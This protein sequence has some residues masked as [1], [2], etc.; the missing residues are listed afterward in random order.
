MAGLPNVSVCLLRVAE[1]LV[2]ACI[3]HLGAVCQ[4][5]LRAQEVQEGLQV[6]AMRGSGFHAVF[7]TLS[8]DFSG[9]HLQPRFFLGFEVLENLIF[10]LEER[11]RLCGW[12]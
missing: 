10:I 7:Q 2:L 1:K 6:L 5:F 11:V 3:S 8:L 12:L 4:L 9:V